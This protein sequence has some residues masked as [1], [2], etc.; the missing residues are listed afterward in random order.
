M[1]RL[2]LAPGKS[3]ASAFNVQS[4]VHEAT[5]SVPLGDNQTRLTVGQIPDWS[6]YEYTLPHEQ[7]FITHNLLFDFTLPSFYTG[8]AIDVTRGNRITSYNVCYTKLLRDK[9]SYR[10]PWMHNSHACT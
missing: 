2:T 8:A 3:A 10:I 5:V 9:R 6:G 1:W 7:P 4:I